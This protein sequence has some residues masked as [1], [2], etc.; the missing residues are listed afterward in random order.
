VEK[1][2][3]APVQVGPGVIDSMSASAEYDAKAVLQTIFVRASSI[4]WAFR[5]E[6]SKQVMEGITHEQKFALGKAK[7]P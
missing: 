6:V 3:A 4:N 2:I 1:K 7:G 5:H